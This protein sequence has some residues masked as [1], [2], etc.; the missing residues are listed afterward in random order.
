MHFRVSTP[1]KPLGAYCQLRA[2]IPVFSLGKKT[3]TFKIL[4]NCTFLFWRACPDVRVVQG[5]FTLF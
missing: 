1:L 3:P 5:V 2:R 4:A